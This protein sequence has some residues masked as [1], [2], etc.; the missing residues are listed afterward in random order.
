MGNRIKIDEAALRRALQPQVD[1]MQA[2]LNETFQ[3]LVRAVRD[4][5]SG[6]PADRVF[7]VLVQ[8]LRDAVPGA[9]INEANLR[10]V[11]QQIEAGT[12]PD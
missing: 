6:Q 8:R 11:A 4:E 1:K 12:L 3:A 2:E 9:N 7:P 10:V 5:M